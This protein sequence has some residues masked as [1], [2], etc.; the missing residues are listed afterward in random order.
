MN[1]T[2]PPVEDRFDPHGF[3]PRKVRG[4]TDVERSS[5]DRMVAGVCS[6]LSR[7]LNIDP[8]IM[9]VILVALTF[10]GFAGVILYAGAW[11]FLPSDDQPKSVAAKWFK[12]DDNEEQVRVVGLIVAGIV[13]ITAG[14]GFF[15]GNWSA[16]F[17]WVGLVA[18]A[19]LYF[20]VIKPAQ[21]RKASAPEG[22]AMSTTVQTA[23]GQTVTQVLPQ[24]KEP[25][26]P[27]SPIL[28]LV[29][30]STSL[31]A[32]G[33]VAIYAEANSSVPWTSYAVAALGVIGLGLL[34]GTFWGNAGPLIPI[35]ALVALVLAVT[36]VLPSSRIGHDVFPASN[37]A[38][39][40]SYKLGIGE[41]ELNLNEL[42]DP[43][44]LDGRTIRI[45]VG[46][47]ETR[48]VV[49]ESTNVEVRSKLHAG[50]IAV[51]GRKVNG[52]ENKLNYPADNPS[53]P[54]LTLIVS[55]TFGN[56]EVIKQ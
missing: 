56:V 34:I 16:P 22:A 18:F 23:D 37:T 20:W 15:D 54:Q 3:D 51:F 4:I 12:L 48:I 5:E 38:V 13:A 28:T 40:D 7:Y 19:A 1:E 9:R 35:G 30:L 52:T 29:T 26:T 31:I 10:A 44:Q 24:P 6:G 41:L 14:T 49:P 21:R 42:N 33:G 46:I 50:E 45:K 2:T 53:A 36:S 32:M 39:A 17:P 55:Q 43:A 11:L 27:W 8:V 47:G 25:K